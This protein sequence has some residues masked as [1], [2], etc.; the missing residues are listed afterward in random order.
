[1]TIDEQLLERL[2]QCADRKT[3]I[4]GIGNTLKA[5]DGAGCVVCER[6]KPD[7]SVDVVDTG[8]VP[9]NYIQ[10]IRKKQSRRIII[11]DAID[12]GGIPG[13]IELFT[14]DQLAPQ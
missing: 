13:S 11:I 6:L 10:H 3:I 8:T 12:F 7:V 9:E 4:V 5:D 14:P 2:K 1:M